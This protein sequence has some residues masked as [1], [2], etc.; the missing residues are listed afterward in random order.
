MTIKTVS[1]RIGSHTTI[2]SLRIELFEV[3]AIVLWM[4][5]LMRCRV[6]DHNAALIKKTTV[7]HTLGLY[8][9]THDL[10]MAML[11]FGKKVIN[12]FPKQRHK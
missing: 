6:A 9:D 4:V 7:A 3:L 5:F 10:Q 11:D 12:I 2:V 8:E 1:S